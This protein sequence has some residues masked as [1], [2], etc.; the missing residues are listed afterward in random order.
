ARIK[1]I[2]INSLNL[3][4]CEYSEAVKLIYD[5][6]S[7]QSSNCF[8]HL[9]LYNYYL[10]NKV[11]P[12][13]NYVL[14]HSKL[15]FEGIGMKIGSL[16]TGQGWNSDINGTDLYPLLFKELSQSLK[17]VFFLGAE[18]SIIRE[19]VSKIENAFPSLKIAG[20]NHGYFKKNEE[21][22]IVTMINISNPDLLIL[23]MG[24]VKEIDFINKHYSHL[25]VGSTWCVGGLFDFI[26]G[27][28][29]R[30]PQFIRTLKI[31]WLFRFLQQPR[32]KFTRNFIVPFWYY[33]H[34]FKTQN[35]VKPINNSLLHD[36]MLN[37]ILTDNQSNT[38]HQTLTYSVN[39]K[40]KAE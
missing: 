19:A 32:K 2:C 14:Q 28:H 10:I 16:L 21:E 23:G 30:A 1:S 39:E 20:F 40:V 8:I 36:S 6:L 27:K 35:K 38:L 26:S 5:S 13:Q 34:L 9:N 31:E 7:A 22:T 18:E 17:T 37:N 33:F 25:K 29:K 12:V 3:T 24:M 15:F 4:S 11:K